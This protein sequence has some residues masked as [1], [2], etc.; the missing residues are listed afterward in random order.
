MLLDLT[1]DAAKGLDYLNAPIHDHGEGP[2]P[3]I[4]GDIKP[5]N[6]LIVGDSLQI[7]DFGLAREIDDLR[8]TATAMGTYAYAAPELLEGHPHV[9]SDQYCLAVS[10][11]ELRTGRSAAFRRDQY[12]EDRRTAP[13]R[14]TRSLG[15]W[16]RRGGGHPQGHPSRSRTAMA[17]VPGNGPRTPPPPWNLIPRAS[18]RGPQLGKAMRHRRGKPPA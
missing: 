7:C 10:Y 8:K 13:R 15:P 12:P 14:Q 1:E 9:R 11:V 16:A 6:L 3:I 18:R 5:Q 17:V 4:H 2:R